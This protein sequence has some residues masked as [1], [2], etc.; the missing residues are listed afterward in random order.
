M[1]CKCKEVAVY[2]IDEQPICLKCLLEFLESPSNFNEGI[3]VKK[4]VH[5]SAILNDLLEVPY[6]N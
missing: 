1:K 6:G 4:Y 2:S 3:V 5:E